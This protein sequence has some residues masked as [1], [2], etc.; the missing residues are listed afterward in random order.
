M[1]D[2]GMLSGPARRYGKSAVT[3]T[4]RL[5]YDGLK[6]AEPVRPLEGFDLIWIDDMPVSQSQELRQSVSAK[7]LRA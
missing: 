5:V 3:A 6:D 1:T 4:W 7:A 2:H